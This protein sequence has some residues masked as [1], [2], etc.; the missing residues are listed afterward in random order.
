MTVRVLA[1]CLV[2]LW[3]C[4]TTTPEPRVDTVENQ[5]E[6]SAPPIERVI[7]PTQAMLDAA[8]R[9]DAQAMQAAVT[10]SGTCEASSTCPAQ[11][12]ACTN[13]SGSFECNQTCGPGVCLCKPWLNPDCTPDD[14]RG[15]IYY[16]S[17]R[18]CFDSAQ[19]ACTEW[20]QSSSTFCGC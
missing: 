11:Y 10:L 2:C 8:Q 13:W 5:A 16:N 1:V 17:Y 18:I 20:S 12:G 14:L 3:A 15:R 6:L 9:G 4:N 7:R 19:N